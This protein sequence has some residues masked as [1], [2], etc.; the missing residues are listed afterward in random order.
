MANAQSLKLIAILSLFSVLLALPQT[1]PETGIVGVDKCD[2]DTTKDDCYV[3]PSL[4]DWL[5]L[6]T[7][8][9]TGE[10][11]KKHHHH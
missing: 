1:I 5:D 8:T 3:L 7:E 9:T 4:F 10:R 11:R 6:V 2:Q